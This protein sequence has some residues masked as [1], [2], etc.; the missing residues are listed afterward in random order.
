MR[1]KL[2]FLLFFCIAT[3]AKAENEPVI[4]LNVEVN[5]AKITLGFEVSTPNTK[6]SIDWG[7][8]VLVETETIQTPDPY[9]NATD[10]VVTPKGEGLIKIYGENIV[11]FSCAPNAKEAKVTALDVTKAVHLTE[12]YANTN[13]LTS[14]DVS[15][16]TKLQIL[17][18]GGNPIT[19]LD[20]TNNISLIYLNANDM[21]INKLDVSK[22]PELDYLSFNNNKL[23]ALDISKN[24]KIQN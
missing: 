8:G 18:C 7:D 2:L 19:A 12:L 17:Y 22:C 14:L 9:L 15:K 6:L 11:Y 5:E 23:E 3:I 13:K 21:G 10:V 24:T 20:L 1:R 4:T 16:N